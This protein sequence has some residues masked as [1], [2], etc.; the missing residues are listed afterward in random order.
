MWEST[1]LTADG[2]PAEGWDGTDKDGVPCIQ[3]SYIWIIEAM[4]TDN[5]PW[6]GMKTSDGSAHTKGNIT[7]IR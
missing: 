4:F 2:Q 7:L 6:P 3:G 1:K 5:N